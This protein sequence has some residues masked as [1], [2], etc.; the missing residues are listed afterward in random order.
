MVDYQ[1]IGADMDMDMDLSFT[2]PW[3]KQLKFGTHIQ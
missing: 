3:G 1:L 2:T